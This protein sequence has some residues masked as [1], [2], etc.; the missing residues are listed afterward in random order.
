M[1]DKQREG[2]NEDIWQ[3]FERVLKEHGPIEIKPD[4]YMAEHNGRLATF[5]IKVYGSWL[6]AA[7][8]ADMEHNIW[9]PTD[10][11]DVIAAKLADHGWRIRPVKLVPVD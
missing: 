2:K 5:C 1:E 6:D 10:S 7:I 8:S 3:A 9:K 4:G 11:L